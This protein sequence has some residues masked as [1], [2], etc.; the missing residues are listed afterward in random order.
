MLEQSAFFFRKLTD[1]QIHMVL[2]LNGHLEPEVLSS[3]A[4]LSLDAEP[5]LG[6][7]FIENFRMPYWQRRTDLDQINLLH[8]VESGNIFKEVLN[9]ISIRPDPV[10]DPLV[11]LLLI[12]SSHDTLCIKMNHVVTDAAGVKHYAAVLSGIYRAL[13]MNPAYR[14][15]A[16]GDVQRGLDRV[17]KHLSIYDKIKVARRGFRDLGDKGNCWINKHGAARNNPVRIFLAI[18]HIDQQRFRKLKEYS[19]GYKVTLNDILVTACYRALSKVYDTTGGKRV[20]LRNTI[21][22]RRYLVAGTPVAISNYSGMLYSSVVK[23]ALGWKFEDVLS[24]VHDDLMFKKGDFAGLGE[25]PLLAFLTR[26]LPFGFNKEIFAHKMKKRINSGLFCPIL[27]NMGPIAANTLEFGSESR[28]S[29]GFLIAPASFNSLIIGVSS[30]CNSMTFATAYN[31]S[32]FSKSAIE[33]L[34]DIFMGELPV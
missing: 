7:R 29:G 26:I 1:Q 18:R 9:F 4:R 13:T 34:L 19:S 25:L 17:A 5:V 27:T 10:K 16:R 15:P 12:R 22:L 31:E 28:V 33:S 14:P 32:V 11:R 20:Y 6:C 23:E 30:C 3:A 21:D 24:K 2:S 8:I